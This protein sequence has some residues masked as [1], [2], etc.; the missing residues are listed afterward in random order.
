MSENSKHKEDTELLVL[1]GCDFEKVT[2]ITLPSGLVL[3]ER[4][5][6]RS[7]ITEAARKLRKIETIVKKYYPQK[8]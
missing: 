2:R 1:M 3:A 7:A 6:E 4:K 8:T 5:D